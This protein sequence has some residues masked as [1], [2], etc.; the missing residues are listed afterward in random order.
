MDLNYFLVISVALLST[1][2]KCTH[3]YLLLL[4]QRR[5]VKLLKMLLSAR[6]TLPPVDCLWSMVSSFSGL[7]VNSDGISFSYVIL[8]LLFTYV[9]ICMKLDPGIHIVMHLV[10]LLKTGCDRVVSELYRL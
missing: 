5:C 10:C 7:G 8:F 2:H 3:P 9:T 4:S 1:N 6:P